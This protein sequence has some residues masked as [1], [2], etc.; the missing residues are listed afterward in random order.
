MVVQ[1]GSRSLLRAL[2]LGCALMARVEATAQGTGHGGSQVPGK[3]EEF[4]ALPQEEKWRRRFPQPILVSD[5]VGRLV[6]NRDQEVLGR[7]DTLVRTP[8]DEVQLV[9]SKR[10][11]LVF[12]GPAVAVPAKTA[13]L[14]GPFV[15]VLDLSDEEIGRLPAWAAGAPPVDPAS[16]IEMALTKR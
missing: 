7:I 3:A 4:A 10:R 13:A 5:L 8:D 15:M 16:R 9:F 12:W 14:L 11:F 1:S 2:A 6:L